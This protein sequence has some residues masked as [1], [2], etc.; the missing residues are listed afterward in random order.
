MVNFCLSC[1]VKNS[2]FILQLRSNQF[3]VGDSAMDKDKEKM[4]EFCEK[5]DKV[6]FIEQVNTDRPRIKFNNCL[7]LT[8]SEFNP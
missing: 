4:A 8:D 5:L 3:L 1:F 6:R 2:I 7:T